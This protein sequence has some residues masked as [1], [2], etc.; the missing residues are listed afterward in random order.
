MN[1][2][3]ALTSLAWR[4]GFNRAARALFARRGSFVLGLHGVADKRLPEKPRSAQ[5]SLCRT[6]LEQLLRWTREHFR[7]LTPDEYFNG[8]SGVL[9]TFDDGFRN[10]HE[11]ALPILRKYDAPAIFFVPTQH[12]RNPTDWLPAT[13]RSA[14][15]LGP[16]P[17]TVASDLFDGMSVEALRDCA[18][19]PLLTIGSHTVSHPFMTQLDDETLRRELVDSKNFLETIIDQSVD[20]FAYPTGDYDERVA[21]AVAAA[22]YR[23]AFVE[24][25]RGFGLGSYELS[26]IG[27]Y[28]VRAAYLST[29]LNGLYRR[30]TKGV[31][32]ADEQHR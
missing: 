6:E 29:K 18:G 17:E 32:C 8:E 9:L 19:E 2:R 27:I 1:F 15:A 14:E 3:E 24:E 31:L 25:S 12:V 28:D 30:P 26:R 21:R 22:G 5:P 13:R 10:H 4:S 20:T 23:A 16:V 7:F 11:N